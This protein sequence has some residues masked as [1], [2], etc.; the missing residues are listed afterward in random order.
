MAIFNNEHYVHAPESL[1]QLYHCK[2]VDS[3][4]RYYKI[5]NSHFP[6]IPTSQIY[7][8]EHDVEK[9]ISIHMPETE[10][11]RFCQNWEQY[12]TIMQAAKNN[13]TVRENYEKLLT[14]SSLIK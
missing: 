1:L 9:I 2:I 4:E 11:Y 14:F 7:Q 8:E 3:G 10:F 12:M 6:S 5:P 13:E